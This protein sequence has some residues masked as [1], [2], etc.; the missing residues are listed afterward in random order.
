MVLCAC[1][2]NRRY[3]LKFDLWC[4]YLDGV[5]KKACDETKECQYTWPVICDVNHFYW[6]FMK[7]ALLDLLPDHYIIL[8]PQR[9]DVE[10]I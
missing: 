6:K 2:P 3:N 5:E 8:H 9:L 10:H 7:V 1:F 4:I